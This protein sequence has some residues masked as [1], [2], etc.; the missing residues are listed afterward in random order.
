M[1]IQTP[2]RPRPQAAVAIAVIGVLVVVSGLT[3]LADNLGLTQF[4]DVLRQLWPFALII[5]GVVTL[6]ARR[7]NQVFLGLALIF[8][9]SWAY[10]S[11]Q[12]WLNVNFWAVFGPTLLIL[13][14]ASIV[15]RA[16]SRKPHIVGTKDA[17]IRS[18][19]ILGGGELRPEAPFEGAELVAIM[20]GAKIDLSNATMAGD[21]AV[22]DIFALMGGVELIVPRD[23]NV[24]VKLVT[25]MGGV[26][27]KRRPSTLPATKQLILRGFAMMGGCEI[28]D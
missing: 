10:A 9:G 27:D 25:F 28:K 2:E 1:Q 16:F 12:H 19:A 26:E 7:H 8:A 4:H 15:W 24:T 11:Q 14:G 20:G 21:T 18:L 5:V 3:L 23:W 13:G 6:L 22:V 17:Y